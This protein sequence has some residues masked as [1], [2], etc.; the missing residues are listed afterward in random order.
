[1]ILNHGLFTAFTTDNLIPVPQSLSAKDPIATMKYFH[2]GA[3]PQLKTFRTTPLLWLLVGYQG[4]KI[5]HLQF[6]TEGAVV[7]DADGNLRAWTHPVNGLPGFP[8][9][10][11]LRG[12][13]PLS[14]A[15][16][17]PSLFGWQRGIGSRE[18]PIT[19]G[20]FCFAF[21][22]ERLETDSERL[23]DLGI[24]KDDELGSLWKSMKR[25]WF[26]VF[27]VKVPMPVDARGR[28]EGEFE[29]PTN[30]TLRRKLV[31]RCYM[32]TSFWAS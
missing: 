26:G 16:Y 12:S 7:L 2:R 10:Y 23:M 21:V 22:Q 19:M 11:N 25:S 8:I 14:L 15:S 13:I 17:W 27:N 31:R 18:V 9:P 4:I 5:R 6:R 24:R 32:P 29:D 1:M 30:E 20:P 28:V 3:I